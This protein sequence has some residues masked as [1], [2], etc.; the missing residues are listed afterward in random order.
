[1]LKVEKVNEIIFK[2]LFIGVRN[3]K[4]HGQFHIIFLP[5]KHMPFG[6]E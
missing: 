5:N 4:C 2:N 3:V 6:G 1:M